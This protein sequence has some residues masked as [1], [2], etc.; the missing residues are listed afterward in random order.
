M[1]DRYSSA[2][3]KGEI[4]SREFSVKDQIYIESVLKG[5][6][7]KSLNKFFGE[8]KFS[9]LGEGWRDFLN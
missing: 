5:S 8:I 9:N 3:K 1:Q 4:Y 6:S 2:I 7:L